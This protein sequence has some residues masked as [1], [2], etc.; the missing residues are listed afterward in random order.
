MTFKPCIDHK[1][2]FTYCI[3]CK[4]ESS[5]MACKS[6]L[7]PHLHSMLNHRD[8]KLDGAKSDFADPL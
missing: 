5:F 6:Q 2:T 1:I 3:G 4:T 7:L 8:L